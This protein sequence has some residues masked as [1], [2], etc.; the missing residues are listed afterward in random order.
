MYTV[1]TDLSVVL[2]GLTTLQTDL[3][4]MGA[5]VDNID[6][7][8]IPAIVA[9]IGAKNIRGEIKEAYLS[10]VNAAYQTVLDITGSGL[11]HYLYMW[12]D[13]SANSACKLS[14]DNITPKE[15]VTSSD[16]WS[17]GFNHS[18]GYGT[19]IFL[20]NDAEFTYPRPFSVSLPFGV[21]F[22]CEIKSNG[23]D[24][25]QALVLYNED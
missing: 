11:V 7:V 23:A 19:D 16:K 25:I 14:W 6:T 17:L 15:H 1:A 5:V 22:K 18:G 20:I 4:A 8:D 24:E 3:T 2:S 9:A 12:S 21:G 10:T 13:A